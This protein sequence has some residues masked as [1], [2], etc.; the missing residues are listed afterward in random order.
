MDL[1]T[2]IKKNTELENLREIK[3]EAYQNWI[4]TMPI[5]TTEETINASPKWIEF[6][7]VVDQLAEHRLRR[8]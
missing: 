2:W 3:R 7:T 1:E 6:I 8:P 4:R 5:D